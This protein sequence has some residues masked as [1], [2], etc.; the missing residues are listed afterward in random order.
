MNAQQL[1][2]ERLDL[3]TRTIDLESTERIPSLYMGV[4][5]APRQMGVT[6]AQF[7]ADPDVALSCTLDYLDKL[8]TL[9]GINL[10]PP[11]KH[12]VAAHRTLVLAPAY[13]RQRTG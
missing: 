8:G 5:P 4:A 2:E 11:T 9:D 3:I 10:H 6:M 7:C 12:H 1:Y 13:A